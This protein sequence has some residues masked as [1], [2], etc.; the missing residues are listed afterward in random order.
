M[1]K[2]SKKKRDKQF[3]RTP[4]TLGITGEKLTSRSGLLVAIH[5]LEALKIKQQADSLFPV[6]G[7][8][9]SYHHSTVVNAFVLMLNEGRKCPADVYH[10]HTGK[11]LLK[12][13]GIE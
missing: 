5:V 8:N 2:G 6:L 13:A 11:K 10:L 3:K 9:I 4:Y 12:L 7:S 1:S